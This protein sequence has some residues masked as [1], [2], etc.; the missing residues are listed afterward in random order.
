[1]VANP[2]SYQGALDA[3]EMIN[4]D[5]EATEIRENM[6]GGHWIRLVGPRRYGKT[7]LLRR[8]LREADAQG[9]ATALVDL[10]EVNTLGSI[11]VRIERAYDHSLKGKLRRTVEQVIRSWGFGVSL[12]AGGFSVRL[13]ANPG[14]DVEG[15]L[16]HVLEL[17]REVH[18]RTG[19]RS[20][21]VFDEV[22]HLLRVERADGILRSVIQHQGQV[23]AY[24]F[25]GS[26]P[27]LVDQLFL[28]PKRP[29]L[30]Q[31]VP[32][33]LEPLNEGDVYAYIAERFERTG[34]DAGRALAPLVE[35]TRGHPQRSMLLAHELWRRTRAGEEADEGT[36]DAALRA[37]LAGL[38]ELLHASFSALSV[39]EQRLATALARRPPSLRHQGT[40]QLVGLR[41][42]SVGTALE[43]LRARAD[44][45][46]GDGVP[47]LTDPLLEHWLA[48]RSRR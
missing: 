37:V 38:E 20:M 31:A 39:N 5:A 34:R 24:A 35:F 13:Q 3:A 32:M 17:P 15:V 14:M 48:E 12:G 40:L 33:E 21:I 22:Q 19:K 1:M 47:R 6:A 28:D 10:E 2:F 36:W 23:A 7:T 30:E 25:A 18:R 27:G 42:G 46:E 29:L 44:I 8:V 45:R 43:G 26:A 4:R 41:K 9:F 11:V 16:L